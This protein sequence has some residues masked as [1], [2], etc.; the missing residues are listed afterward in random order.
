MVYF[1]TIQNNEEVEAAGTDEKA[2]VDVF[3]W[4]P[5]DD[6]V[7]EGV[8]CMERRR[9]NAFCGRVSAFPPHQSINRS[10]RRQNRKGC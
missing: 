7:W 8:V 6:M 5:G 4:E 9:R 2:V 1:C 3:D 10:H